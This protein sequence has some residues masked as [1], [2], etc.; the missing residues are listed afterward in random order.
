TMPRVSF[1]VSD[2]FYFYATGNTVTGIQRVQQELCVQ[3]A[4]Q[5]QAHCEFVIYDRNV[6]KWRSVSKE[7]LLSLIEAARAFRPGG[8]PWSSIYEVYAKRALTA[9]LKQF[10]PGEWLTNVGASWALA[11]YFVQV[12][13]LRRRGVRLA[14]FCHDLIPA[15]HPAYFDH[16]HT[17]EH[18]YWLAQIR[19]TADVVFC[20][21]ESTR[22][23][24]LE[25]VKPPSQP[26][27]V[28]RLDATW[29]KDH[30]S[31]EADVAATELLSDLSVFDDEFVLCVGT[32][33]P[34]KNHLTLIHVWDKLRHTHLNGCPKLICVGRIGW[35]SDAVISQA[36]ALGLLNSQIHFL[37]GLSDDVLQ[38]LYRKCLFTMYVSYYEGW[39]L[40][41]TESLAAGKLCIAGGNSALREA[42][43]NYAVY[44]DERS[45][46]SI[47]EAICRFLD[48]R[49]ALNEAN[50]RVR[51]DYRPRAWE[52][53]AREITVT[54]RD[55]PSD[56]RPTASLPILDINTFYRFGRPEPVKTFDH[57]R[58]AEIFCLGQAWYQPE[59]WGTW[60][61][62]EAAEIGFRISTANPRPT[63]FLG[64]SS[65]PGPPASLI[66]AVNGKQIKTVGEFTG[67]KVVRI[68]LEEE[69]QHAGGGTFLPVRI[70]VT[71]SRIQNMREIEGSNDE[72]MLGVAYLFIVG[73]DQTSMAERLEFLEQVVADEI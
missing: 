41:I 29:A 69:R 24:Y 63:V 31:P 33:E 47:Y 11:S 26:V 17:I 25:I 10:D 62:R 36:K 20:N 3:F 72:R 22:R 71:A 21:S 28:C 23:D 5:D 49:G 40:P 27:A 39:G 9:P 12:R 14:V 59:S 58:A 45:E 15:R 42:G 37:S 70:R 34:R 43:S 66:I 53:I 13:Q 51:R 54:L 4:K 18:T 46:T 48:N 67:R 30:I 35:K 64:L 16:I 60:T 56:E 44:V 52:D 55:A 2:L 6:Q 68:S 1:E 8:E 19:E 57:P 38:A 32:I 65:P 7:W 73:F 61:A 50:A